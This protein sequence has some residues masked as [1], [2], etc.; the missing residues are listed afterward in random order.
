M[1]FLWVG[2]GSYPMSNHSQFILSGKHPG[3]KVYNQSD[4]ENP[5]MV[6]DN[7]GFLKILHWH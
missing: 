4:L 3:V 1:V 2:K 7:T 5:S 6:N